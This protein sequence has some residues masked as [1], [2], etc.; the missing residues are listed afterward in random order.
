M[1]ENQNP[2]MTQTNTVPLAS[3]KS[4]SRNVFAML[5]LVALFIAFGILIYAITMNNEAD[6]ASVIK[7]TNYLNPVKQVPTTP[8]QAEVE[9]TDSIEV[10]DIDMELQDLDSDL[11]GL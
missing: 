2:V 7:P 11:E 1:E 9:G 6:Y 5:I 4:G 8:S 10:G 3:N